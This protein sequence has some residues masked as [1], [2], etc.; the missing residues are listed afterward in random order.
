LPLLSVQV[1]I[2]ALGSGLFLSAITAKYR[3]LQNAVGFIINSLM[4]VTPVMWPLSTMETKFPQLY[5]PL[6]VLNPLMSLVE[7]FR[8]CMIGVGTFSAR[9]YAIS[10]VSSILI[11]L[12]GLALFQRTARTFV[13][14]A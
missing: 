7:A 14:Q 9:Y 1:A 10:V 3:D 13:D 4:F 2:L 8:F 6:M 12:V 5:G 11:L